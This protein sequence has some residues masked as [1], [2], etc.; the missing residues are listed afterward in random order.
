MREV[1][2]KPIM[3]DSFTWSHIGRW[4]VENF[5]IPKPDCTDNTSEG[6]EAFCGSP[7]EFWVAVVIS[8]SG[9]GGGEGGE[10]EGNEYP[11]SL[12]MGLKGWTFKSVTP[13]AL[14]FYL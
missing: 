8:G 14:K 1:S 12:W 5:E 13:G 10:R 3:F 9:R 2:A 7:L 6:N 4:L 11:P